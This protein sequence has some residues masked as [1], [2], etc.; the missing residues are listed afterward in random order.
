MN[1]SCT[2]A[3]K[4]RVTKVTIPMLNQMLSYCEWAKTDGSYYGNE[5]NFRRRHHKIVAWL[6]AILTNRMRKAEKW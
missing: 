4:K 1:T 6:D 2:D 3:A 5:K